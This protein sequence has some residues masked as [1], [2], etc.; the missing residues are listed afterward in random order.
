MKT[1]SR[2][3]LSRLTL[4]AV[5]SVAV[6]ATT[7]FTAEFGVVGFSANAAEEKRKKTR[8]VPTISEAAFKKL[9]KAGELIELKD[10]DGALE[11]LL[12]MAPR[13]R[14]YNGN[15]LGNI[16]YNLA[17][18]YYLK[19]DYSK[20]IDSYKSVL[21]QGE[22][23]SEGTEINTLYTV[24][25]LCSIEGR[26]QESLDFMEIWLTKANNPGPEPRVF[27]GQVYYQMKDFSN[28]LIQ[29]EMA[30]TMA[31]ER[32]MKP[33]ENWWQL[34]A[35][36][37]FE[38]EDWPSYI[39]TMKTLVKDFPKRDYWIQLAGIY[40]Q[41]GEERLQLNTMQAAYAADVFA[42]QGDFT[43]LAGLLLQRE[44]PYKAAKVMRDGFEQEVIERSAANLQ[45]LGQAWQLSQEV[46]EAI[47]VLEEAATLSDEGKI[48]ERLAYLYMEDDSYEKCVVAANGALDKGGLRKRQTI[49]IVRGMCEYN[50]NK[51]TPARGSFVSCRNESRKD[52]DSNNRRI[53]NQWI[54]FID[55]EADRQKQLAAAGG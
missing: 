26:F 11:I 31:I 45:S 17:Y 1:S 13:V 34:I 6:L 24:A 12:E 41:E 33:K 37:Y 21:A 50:Q 47:P 14:R 39:E 10:Y 19:E 25:Q 4:C 18:I 52:E 48:Y 3:T 38:K 23:V 15:E 40:G 27:L 36:M 2:L 32:N 28:A 35:F 55:R 42:R 9:G 53:C 49:Y 54:T 43:N 8:R 29:L 30:I 20:A 51:L 7:P 46:D 16:Y 5:L 44:A 22:E